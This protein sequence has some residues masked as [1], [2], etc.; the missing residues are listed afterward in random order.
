MKFFRL[1]CMKIGLEVLLPDVL[2]KEDLVIST[3]NQEKL[4]DFWHTNW[5]SKLRVF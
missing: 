5:F 3:R 4:R 2:F 1:K